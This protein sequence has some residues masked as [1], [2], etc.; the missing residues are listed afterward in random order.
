MIS[1]LNSGSCEGDMTEMGFQSQNMM[2]TVSIWR[3]SEEK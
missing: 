2:I 3:L 1:S